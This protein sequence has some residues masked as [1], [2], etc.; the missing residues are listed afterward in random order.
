MK[1]TVLDL[2]KR[3]MKEVAAGVFM[4]CY[5]NKLPLTTSGHLRII[6]LG[7]GAAFSQK[8]FQSN[9]IIVKGDDALWVDLGSKTTVKMTELKLVVH[10]IKNILITHSH[11]DHVG[12]LEEL[13]LKRRYE[14]PF[15]EIKQQSG[16]PFGEYLSRV[17]SARTS[18]RFRPKLY[19]PLYY[20]QQLWGWSLKGGLAFSEEVELG[21]N[22]GEMIKEHFF[23]FVHPTPLESDSWTFNVGKIKIQT[24]LN[25]HI[26]DTSE[27]VSE[28]FYTTGLVV[29]GKVYISGDTRFDPERIARF[30]KD[31]ETLFH[32]CQHFP[33]GVHAFYGELKTLPPEIKNKTYLYHLSD[34]ML[35]IDVKADGFAGFMEP[36]PIVY[37]FF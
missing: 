7:V 31:K 21:G 2:G 19:V 9:L 1:K 12:S 14:A 22:K 23:D 32:D 29:D 25:K 27:R 20:A 24:F 26:P 4:S 11:A 18:G 10:D 28:S 30:G 6:A 13:A 8:M 34:G 35:E 15:M 5:E 17:V 16:E 37:D 36:A 33:G 3:E